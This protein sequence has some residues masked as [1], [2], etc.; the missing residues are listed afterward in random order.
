MCRLIQATLLDLWLIS[1][2][3]I[4]HLAFTHMIYFKS[5]FAWENY[6]AYTASLSAKPLHE[7]T[8][9]P[10][11]ICMVTCYLS[12]PNTTVDCWKVQLTLTS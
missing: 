5:T 11:A 2:S 3:G 7:I 12:Q 10:F 6:C 1:L 8:A 9:V 4:S